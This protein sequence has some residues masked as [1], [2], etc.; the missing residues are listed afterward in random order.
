MILFILFPATF[1]VEKNRAERVSALSKL[2]TKEKAIAAR[3]LKGGCTVSVCTPSLLQALAEQNRQPG[4]SE[5][6][7]TPQTSPPLG[8]PRKAVFG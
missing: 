2:S 3:G 7:S 4:Q 5:C 8:L 6:P 1:G